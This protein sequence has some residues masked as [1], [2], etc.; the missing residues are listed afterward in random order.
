MDVSGCGSLS[1][2]GIKPLNSRRSGHN[3]QRN[4]EMEGKEIQSSGGEI[5]THG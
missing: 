4:V 1:M 3:F 2:V 5:H